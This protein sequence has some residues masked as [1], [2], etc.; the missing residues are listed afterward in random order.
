MPCPRLGVCSAWV[1]CGHGTGQPCARRILG[2]F[3]VPRPLGVCIYAF[4]SRPCANRRNLHRCARL[5]APSVTA[6]CHLC[7]CSSRGARPRSRYRST[8]PAL[9][10]ARRRYAPQCF[11]ALW[12]GIR[13]AAALLALR[14]VPA[15]IRR[16]APDRVAP[17]N[18]Q[19]TR[20]AS[21]LRL[22]ESCFPAVA[23]ASHSQVPRL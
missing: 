13:R 7:R 8:L 20:R 10:T 15:P 4:G 19:A 12:L 22:D 14:R 23:V 18:T 16:T 11:V 17:L 3:R 2:D 5:A 6:R 21:S 9:P 1:M